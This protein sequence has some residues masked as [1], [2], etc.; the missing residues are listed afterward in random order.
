MRAMKILRK[1]LRPLP[2]AVVFSFCLAAVIWL[3]G[4]RM[5]I[6]GIT[7][8]GNEI[9]RGWAAL[10]LTILGVMLLVVW[11]ISLWREYRAERSEREARPLTPEQLETR[12]MR[13]VFER[14]TSVIA[15]RWEGTGDPING[16]PWYLVMGA[17]GSGKSTMITAS[18]TR[19]PIDHELAAA[20][21]ELRDRGS[22][23]MLEWH[24]AGSD[25]VLL[26]LSG[27]AFVSPEMRNPLQRHVWA[28]FLKELQRIRP[29]RPLN[30]VVVAIDLAEFCEMDAA[31][32][33][34]YAT[35]IRRITD[36]IVRTIDTRITVH[37]VFTKLDLVA[38][39]L[40]FFEDASAAERDELLGFHFEANSRKP[41]LEAFDEAY[42]DFLERM[43]ARLALR[44]KNLKGVL[45]RQEAFAFARTFV[46]LRNPLRS[47][48]ATAL[49][50]DRF[51]TTPLL[52]G[53]YFAAPVQENAPR[54]IFL[55]AVGARY[56]LPSPLYS[57]PQGAPQPY[58]AAQVFSRAILPEAGLAGSSRSADRNYARF[59]MVLG[60]A[61]VA[62][63]GAV[64]AFWF[65]KY[66]EN[67][68]R[69]SILLEQVEQ[70]SSQQI[71]TDGPIELEML[72]TIR[73][74]TNAFGEYRDISR[75]EAILTLYKGLELGPLADESYR[76]LLHQRFMVQLA[77]SVESDLREVCP[78]GSD[79]QLEILRVLRMFEAV[80]RRNLDTIQSYFRNRWRDQYPQNAEMQDRLNSHLAYA[81]QIEP[82][83]YEIDQELVRSAQIDLGVMTPYRR[84]YSSIRA[85]AESQLPNAV[86]FRSAVGATFDIVY[87]ADSALSP[88]REVLSAG[89]GEDEQRDECGRITESTV[90]AD[91]FEIPRFFTR[92]HYHS[93][94]VPQ[95]R[96]VAQVALDD[97][98][99]LGVGDNASFSDADL[100]QITENLRELYVEDYIR[101]WRQGLNSMQI[102]PF[103][104]LR[105][106]GEV[107]RGLSGVDSPIR[108]I[109]ALV[110]DNT[111]IYP[112]ET[113]APD[114]A[115]GGATQ[116]S[117]DKDRQAGLR[118]NEDFRAIHRLLS[119]EEGTTQTDIA[120]IES[121][122][123]DLYEYM[124]SVRDAPRPNA[125]ALELAIE[126]ANL[127]GADPIFVVQRLAERTPAPFNAH[128]RDVARESWQVIMAA[129]TQELNRKWN[130]EIYGEF[131]R[132]IAGRYPFDRESPDDLPLQDFENFFGPDGKLESFFQTELKTFVD[133]NTGVPRIID[134]QFLPV[135]PDF[136]ANLRRA[137][138]ITH[139]F[140]DNSGDISVQFSVQPI[141]MSANLSRAQLNFEGQLV[142]STHGA[143]RPVRIVWPNALSGTPSSRMDLSPLARSGAAASRQYDGPWSWLRLYDSSQKSGL[144]DNSVDIAFG[145]ANGQSARFRIRSEGQVNPFFNS[146][147]SNFSLPAY[148]RSPEEGS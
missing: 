69:A 117:F 46:G 102:R 59:A 49:D 89:P 17:P 118:I 77:T 86:E 135:D 132:F 101:A 146:P 9:L 51:S 94:F 92:E 37:V 112:P 108:R 50:P 82:Q 13:Q 62:G 78:R 91:P 99:V 16:L 56:A 110:T 27:N 71:D 6:F 74:A 40:D 23:T 106:A 88:Q 44:M 55:Q 5:T 21:A 121:A 126:R 138:K 122:L 72:N 84:F 114:T 104:D 144:A 97:L 109:A 124:K 81:L 119:G 95:A 47:F 25:A 68:A 127:R 143:A 53:V 141:G 65:G 61:C 22:G 11:F 7:P 20:T 98:W 125:K 90:P 140:F 80:D 24:V 116:L 26:Q 12:A 64:S 115:A 45:S 93:F 130:E 54:N 10:F 103:S 67:L 19:R 28:R 137:I 123:T 48:L 57:V 133:E 36:E 105:E 70:Y 38:G 83:A 31:A 120:Q 131:Q 136:T 111:V 18:D 85:L 63:V 43:Q 39:F 41:W 32:R 60:A 129:A 3:F 76:Q 42:A 148:L 142:I 30:G 96:A 34:A 113:V 87:R 15:E 79:A 52:R 107:L 1:F 8:F 29:R 2:L 134:G 128:L 100:D 4:A 66:G 145:T 35:S 73:D 75:P 147:L 139:T 33:D 14:A 58:F